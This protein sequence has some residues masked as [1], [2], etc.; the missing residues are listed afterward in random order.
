[1]KT[2]YKKFGGVILA[3]TIL[4]ASFWAVAAI[5]YNKGVKESSDQ[6]KETELFLQ[7]ACDEIDSNRATIRELNSQLTDYEKD[8]ELLKESIETIETNRDTIQAKN[9]EIRLLNTKVEY[10]ENNP[11]IVEKVVTQTVEV[12]TY[13]TQEVVKEVPT[14]IEKEVVKEVPQES[15][16]DGYSIS[17]EEDGSVYIQSD[18]LESNLTVTSQGSPEDEETPS[19]NTGGNWLLITDK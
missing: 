12:P 14:Y 19:T 9:L 8:K 10:L 11:T 3:L 2:N 13:I 17:Q 6:L 7:E 5:A 1:M 4:L 18:N 16:I 15:P